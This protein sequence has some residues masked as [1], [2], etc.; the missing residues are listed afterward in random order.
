MRCILPAAPLYLVDLLFYLE[1]FEVVEFRLMG[2]ELR[3]EFVLASL[4]LRQVSIHLCCP[5]LP[6]VA[7]SLIPLKQDHPAA[8]VPCCKVISCVVELDGR[9]YVRFNRIFSSCDSPDA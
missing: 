8:F 3:M 4:F 6:V 1:G 9:Y 2:L 5:Y 7:Y